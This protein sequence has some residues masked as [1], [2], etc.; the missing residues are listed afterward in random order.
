MLFIVVQARTNAARQ[1][2]LRKRFQETFDMRFFFFFLIENAKCNETEMHFY[3]ALNR[4]ENRARE[5]AIIAKKI[6][7]E[8]R[9]IFLYFIMK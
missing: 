9:Y 1:K 5:G 6:K 4:R 2:N 7:E 8:I 3:A